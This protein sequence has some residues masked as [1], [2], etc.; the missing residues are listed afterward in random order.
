MLMHVQFRPR[1]SDAFFLY[2]RDP[3]NN[4]IELYAGDYLITD[5]D[6]QPIR[7]RLDD[8]Q[9]ATYWGHPA[10]PSWF[11]EA[12][13]VESIVDGSLVET[14]PPTLQDRPSFVR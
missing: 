7:W 10:P 13:Q 2:L 6:W 3:D 1:L 4:R 14:R 12:S 11:N 9:R 5:P 8:P